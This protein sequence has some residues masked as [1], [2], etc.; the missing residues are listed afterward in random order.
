MTPNCDQALD[1]KY[2]REST[3]SNL[4]AYVHVSVVNANFTKF[5]N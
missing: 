2:R 5:F 3:A 1:K 4:V